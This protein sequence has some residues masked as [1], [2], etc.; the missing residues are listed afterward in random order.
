MSIHPS[1]FTARVPESMFAET[2]DDICFLRVSLSRG[3]PG[4]V[5]FEGHK[6]Q[7]DIQGRACLS[8]NLC[9]NLYM[10]P[11]LV[12]SLGTLVKLGSQWQDVWCQLCNL[13]A[14]ACLVKTCMQ[15]MAWL[16]YLLTNRSMLAQCLSWEGAARKGMHD[17]LM[18]PVSMTSAP[19]SVLMLSWRGAIK[20]PEGAG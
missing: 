14:A 8:V 3:V 9:Y 7:V 4:G 5:V 12:A 20:E 18:Y 16:A 19:S 13:H 2:L 17:E 10:W 1:R 6:R 15:I 11:V